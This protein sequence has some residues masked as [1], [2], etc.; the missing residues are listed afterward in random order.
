[1]DGRAAR[2]QDDDAAIVEDTPIHGRAARSNEETE[3]YSLGLGLFIVREIVHAHA[4]KIS[5]TSEDGRTVC[6]LTLPRISPL[7]PVASNS[8]RQAR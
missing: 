4:G 3:P 2:T 8:A 1:M 6:T 5:V 7:A